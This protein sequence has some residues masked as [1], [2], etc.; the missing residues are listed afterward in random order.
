MLNNVVCQDC[1]Q[2][3]SS[4]N[5]VGNLI[6]VYVWW[7][8]KSAPISSVTDSN[9]NSYTILASTL[10]TNTS[11]GG[12]YSNELAYASNI[13]SGP[14]TVT[15]HLPV[16]SS[17]TG[18]FIGE[19]SGIATAFPLDQATSIT[20]IIPQGTATAGPVTTTANGEL[21]FAGFFEPNGINIT[22]G[23]G[24]TSRFNDNTFTLV[25]DKIQAAAG[26]VTSSVAYSGSANPYFASMVTFQTAVQRGIQVSSRSDKL[27][28]SR[29]SATSNHTFAFTVNNQI[30][31]SSTKPG[32]SRRF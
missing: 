23:T 26:S 18:V 13:A 24:Y 5:T 11:A 15:V 29:P 22:V 32:I 12:D 28:D 3:F 4:N 21:I 20:A 9:G 2:A 8:D 7:N 19:Y 1:S 14:N 16:N 31:G 30:T 17:H 25:E 27:S 6:V 10:A